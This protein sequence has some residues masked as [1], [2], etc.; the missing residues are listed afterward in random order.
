MP[1]GTELFSLKGRVALVTGAGRGIGFSFAKGLASAGAHVVINDIA[2]DM[3]NAAVDS[4]KSAGWSAEA[5]P[6]DVTD[7][8]AVASAV[9]GIVSRNGRLDILMVPVDGG[10]TQSLSQMSE[11]ATRLYSSMILPMHRHATPLAE[12]TG[13]MGEGFAVEFR[14]SRSL[15]VSLETLPSRPTI[16]VLDGV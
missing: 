1:A 3:A 8:P 2:P 15:T 12:F 4:L 13:R 11:V 7:N 9:D 16:V 6:F 14:P 5:A 10:M